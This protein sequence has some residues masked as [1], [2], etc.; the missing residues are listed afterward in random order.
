MNGGKN[1]NYSVLI[2]VRWILKPVPV[3]AQG[4]DLENVYA[5]LFVKNV[6]TL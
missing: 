4:A 6:V 5:I 2:E 1:V 3:S